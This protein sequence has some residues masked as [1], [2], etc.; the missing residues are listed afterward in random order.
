M[1]QRAVLGC[2]T[3]RVIG[4]VREHGSRMEC[5]ANVR[6]LVDGVLE[7]L[8]DY[9]DGQHAPHAT[10]EYSVRGWFE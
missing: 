10:P 5:I 2:T 3:K 9:W 6:W 1:S 4:V 7:S 8:A